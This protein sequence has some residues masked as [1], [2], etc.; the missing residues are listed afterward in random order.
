MD[1]YD[2]TTTMMDIDDGLEVQD[3]IDGM[4]DDILYDN[5]D[6]LRHDHEH[7]DYVHSA[8]DT[9]M[10]HQ[11]TRNAEMA[12]LTVEEMT[13]NQPTTSGTVECNDNLGIADDPAANPSVNEADPMVNIVNILFQTSL[14]HRE[15][16]MILHCATLP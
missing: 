3:S 14:I 1:Q 9:E 5:R 15:T 11:S 4:D 8:I 12:G 13:I 6:E 10:P 16:R 2:E 7:P